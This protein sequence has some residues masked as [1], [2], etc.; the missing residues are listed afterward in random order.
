[1]A[2]LTEKENL[3]VIGELTVSWLGVP[4]IIDGNIIGVMALQSYIVDIH[5][6]EKDKELMIFVGQHVATALMRKKNK[7]YL[8]LLVE[9]RTHELTISNKK[10]HKEI[11][12]RKNSEN[13]QTALFKISETQQECATVEAL[14]SRV[15]EIISQLMYAESFYIALVDKEK[16]CFNFDYV[17]DEVDKNIPKSMPI[18]KSLTSYVYHQRKIVHIN[19]ADIERL[20]SL[21]KIKIWGSYPMDWVGVPL[22]SGT[23]IFGILGVQSY[24][25]NHIYGDREVEV[26]NF[27]STHIA[28]ALERTRA[29]KRLELAHKELAEKSRKAEA[30]SEAKSSFLATVSH[31]IRTPMN[32]ILGM[33][34]L[35]AD[36]D[37]TQKQKDYVSKISISANSL[38]GIIN[39]ILDYSKIEEGKLKLE[40]SAFELIDLLDDL[41]DIFSDSIIE[42]ELI[43]NIDM[44]PE[45]ILSR[46]GDPLRLSQILINLIGNA[47]KFTHKGYIN[48][49]VG[50]P[51]KNRLLF[52]IEDSGIGIPV[53][54]RDKIFSSFTQADDTTTRKFGGSGLGLSICQQLVSM[55]DGWIKVSG[56][57][58]EGSCFSFEITLNEGNDRSLDKT[59]YALNNVLLLSND[60]QQR[61]SWQH[62]F[63][64]FGIPLSILNFDQLCQKPEMQAKKVSHLFIND[65]LQGL[66]TLNNLTSIFDSEIPRFL[67]CRQPPD[68][69]KYPDINKS[70]QYISKPTK[71]KFV[72]SLI[73]QG[74]IASKSNQSENKTND[75][76]R[77]KIRGRKVLLAEDNLI[78]QQVAKEILTQAGAIVSVVDNGLLAVEACKDNSFDFILM[79]MQMPTMDGYQASECIRKEYSLDQLPIIAMT[80]NVM[81]GDKEKCLQHGMNDYI[82][83]PINRTIFFQT[84]EKYLVDKN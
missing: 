51:S 82:S 15:H 80:A 26:L 1:M 78:N 23:S 59:P 10:L 63:E 35:I 53:N 55:M 65:D 24:D 34:S 5:L 40:S 84:I 81:K 64:K 27:V 11:T 67:L 38:L 37:M 46:V 62:F 22:L 2:L 61:Q 3:D 69:Q 28:D 12:Q 71:M 50:A 39:D 83:K 16:D 45:V 74:K 79:D 47:I 6:T 43:F 73:K 29:R 56:V 36:T 72:L 14:Y 8:Q 70:M 60:P 19:R 57:Y 52:L 32:G 68:T 41:V 7:D 9:K 25:K 18:G 33:L 20:E 42:K 44:E 58:G 30:A 17:V 76:I 75:K 77:Q 31:E 66:E 4:L 21:G 48:V 13:L 54:K 49:V